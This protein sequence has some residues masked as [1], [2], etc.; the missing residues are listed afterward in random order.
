MCGGGGGGTPNTVASAP[1]P[2]VAA[3]QKAG[4]PG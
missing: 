4:W 3:M 2:C 1:S